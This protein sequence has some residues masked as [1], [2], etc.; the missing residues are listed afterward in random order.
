MRCRT[1]TI[2]TL[3]T[4]GWLIGCSGF[5]ARMAVA[6]ATVRFVMP[7]R[8]EAFTDADA[9]TEARLATDVSYDGF[10]DPNGTVPLASDAYHVALW[11]GAFEGHDVTD[12]VT[13]LHPGSYTFAFL[14]RDQGDLMQGWLKVNHERAELVDLLCRWRDNI[15]QQRRRSAYDFEISGR[16][17]HS[18]PDAFECFSKQ[19]DAIDRLESRLDETIEAELAARTTRHERVHELFHGVE[20]QIMP[21][22]DPLFHPGTRPAFNDKNLVAV[23]AGGAV[24][25]IVLLADYEDAQWK[26]RRVDQLY[27]DLMRCKAVTREAADRFERRKGLFLLTNHLHRHD[28]RFVENE[29]RLQGALGAIER[30]DEQLADLRQRRMALAFISGL[31][32]PKDHF[33]AL[34]KDEQDLLHERA[35]LEAENQRLDVLFEQAEESQRKRVTLERNRQQVLA[36]LH[37]LDRQLEDLTEARKALEAMTASTDVIHRQGDTRLTAATFVEED[38]PFT[39]RRAV[40]HESLMTLRLESS[41]NVF[42]PKTTS[43]TAADRPADKDARL[44]R[45]HEETQESQQHHQSEPQ[46]DQDAEETCEL[47]WLIRVLVPPCWFDE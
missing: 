41:D 14:D 21:G 31:V 18:D 12:G 2:A 1:M 17:S 37:A 45:L 22:G 44:V 43:V 33:K 29:I 34:D 16:M 47:P 5:N 40:E 10:V 30:L 27:G 3:V 4:S 7:P 11:G 8:P 38:M 6:P 26:L 25:K 39:L 9:D 32:A 46:H 42:V 24:T 19:L 15:P 20:I 28:G 35:V 23:R 13:R 36:A